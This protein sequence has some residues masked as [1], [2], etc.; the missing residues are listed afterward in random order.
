[1]RRA[2]GLPVFLVLLFSAAASCEIYKWA[3]TAGNVQFGDRPP[4]SALAQPV[5]IRPV[6]TFKSVSVT[7]LSS[8]EDGDKTITMYSASWCGVCKQ[9]RQY[10]RKNRISYKEY[11]IETTGKG[12][13]D[14][15]KLKGTGVP[16]ILIGKKRMNGFNQS[17][18]ESLYNG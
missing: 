6:N 15:R 18:F 3:D 10:F 11:D 9:A 7:E 14:F 5:E 16:I 12:K 13:S 8:R 4:A 17:R 1:M 2:P